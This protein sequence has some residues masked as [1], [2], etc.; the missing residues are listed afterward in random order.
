MPTGDPFEGQLPTEVPLPEAPLVRVLAQVRFPTIASIERADA[1]GPFQ[2]KIRAQYP[3]LRQD[4]VQNITLA[5]LLAP[6]MEPPTSIWRFTKENAL[7]SEDWTIALTKDFVALEAKRY[8]SRDDFMSRLKDVLAAIKDTFQPPAVDRIGVRYIDRIQGQDVVDIQRLVQGHAL[9]VIGTPV[10]SHIKQHAVTDT[11][12]SVDGG[13][14]R[15]RWGRLPPHS[16]IDPVAIE[17]IGVESWILDLDA[18]TSEKVDFDP[19]VIVKRARYFAERI[20]AFF[21]WSVTDQF[22]LRFG[23]T[24]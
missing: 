23:G 4:R 12:F 11:V 21:R 9:G 15:A 18:S 1:V 7:A 14:I 16:T 6:A 8:T 5:P 10:G 13:E 2:E 24:P 22:L 17:P 20:Y 19:D 3:F